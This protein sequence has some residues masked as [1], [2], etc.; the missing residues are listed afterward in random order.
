MN[1]STYKTLI[2]FIASIFTLSL[3]AF[4]PIP[5][6]GG[7]FTLISINE[8]EFSLCNYKQKKVQDSVKPVLWTLVN[9]SRRIG[10]QSEPPNPNVSNY[11]PIIFTLPMRPI[12][13][14]DL[15]IF[16]QSIINEHNK[17]ILAKY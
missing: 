16:M 3:W 8:N 13:E 10:I 2:L 14:A 5:V 6:L 15:V 9:E 7:T 17:N 11:Y 4:N 1:Y 12:G